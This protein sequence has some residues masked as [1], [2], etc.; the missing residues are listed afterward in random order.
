MRAGNTIPTG[1]DGFNNGH[2]DQLEVLKAYNLHRLD[3]NVYNVVKC[4]CEL[5]E[6]KVSSSF[7]R[8]CI[9]IIEPLHVIS[10]KVAF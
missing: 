1:I 9:L 6:M 7:A 3:D 4:L 2:F 8:L 10:K 5:E